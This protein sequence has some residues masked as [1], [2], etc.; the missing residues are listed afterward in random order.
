[1]NTDV[2]LD[3][4]IDVYVYIHIYI[5]VRV[6]RK[7]ERERERERAREII[8]MSSVLNQLR[9]KRNIKSLPRRLPCKLYQ[10]FLPQEV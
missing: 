9:P 8:Y 4:D 7:R 5:Y 10:R 1:M 3:M 6:E 2:G